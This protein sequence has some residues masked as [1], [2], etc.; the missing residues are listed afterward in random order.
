M[1]NMNGNI[2]PLILVLKVGIINISFS[3]LNLFFKLS[4][5]SYLERPVNFTISKLYPY[6][7]SRKELYSHFEEVIN[8]LKFV[9]YLLIFSE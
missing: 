1:G 7:V 3:F 8:K 4:R 9:L 6:L 2:V 5:L